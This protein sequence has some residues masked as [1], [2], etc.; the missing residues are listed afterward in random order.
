MGHPK[1][2]EWQCAVVKI[3]AEYRM[4]D[5]MSPFNV[6]LNCTRKLEQIASGRRKEHEWRLE[7]EDG[8]GPS[9]MRN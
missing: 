1:K 3:H 5:K 9:R 8:E 2:R 6:S 7:G 4:L